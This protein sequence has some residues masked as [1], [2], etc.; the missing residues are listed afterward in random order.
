[1]KTQQLNKKIK[2]FKKVNSDYQEISKR[3]L[4]NR[5]IY[6]LE[7]D[8]ICDNVIKDIYEQLYY[9]FMEDSVRFNGKLKKGLLIM[10]NFGSGKTLAIEVFQIFTFLIYK[11]RCIS[12]IFNDDITTSYQEK[13]IQGILNFNVDYEIIID[14]FGDNIGKQFN[15]GNSVNSIDYLLCKRYNMFRYNKIKTHIITNLNFDELQSN[16]SPKLLDRFNEMF[17][18]IIFTHESFRK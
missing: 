13:G 12:F 11:S 15:Y 2:Q 6:F 14:E 5:I 10:G 9:Y 17:N 4:L 7:P 3:E 16:I 1:M 18:Q 8:F